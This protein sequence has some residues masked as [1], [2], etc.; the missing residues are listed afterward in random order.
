VSDDALVA[1]L[2]SIGTG[3]VVGARRAFDSDLALV[4]ASLQDSEFFI[5]ECRAQLYRGDTALHVTAFAYDTGTAARL[6]S[7]GADVRARNR[8]GAEPLHAATHGGPGAPHWRPERQVEIIHALL[9]V[10]ADVDATASGG[11]TPLHRAVR[12][13]CSAAVRALLEAGA[14]VNR[15]NDNGSTP[16][17]LTQHTTGRGGT[18]APEAKAEQAI[19]IELLAAASR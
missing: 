3:D 8:R 4:T 16:L 1:L 7:L 18:G 19:I 10:G 15:Q 17:S 2:R 9:A 6:L 13:R 11:V 14:D 5:D 12:N